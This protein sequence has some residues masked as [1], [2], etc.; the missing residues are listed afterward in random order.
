MAFEAY[1]KAE[2]DVI[3]PALLGLVTVTATIIVLIY[4]R[5]RKIGAAGFRGTEYVTNLD[6][7][8]IRRS[9]RLV[10]GGAPR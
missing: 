9:T 10:F 8:T 5:R 1:F 2:N 7:S 4:L 6:G 3:L